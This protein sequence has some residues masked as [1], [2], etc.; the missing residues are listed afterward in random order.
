MLLR[1]LLDEPGRLF[2]KE[3]LMAALWPKAV[4]TDDSLVQCVGELRTALDDRAQRLIRTVPRRGYRL[5]AAVEKVFETPFSAPSAASLETAET[6][7]QVRRPNEMKTGQGSVWRSKRAWGWMAL[8]AAL[9]GGAALQL[10]SERA[11][12]HIDAMIAARS[13]VAIMRFVPSVDQPALRQLG[14]AVA[15]EIAAQFASRIGMRGIGRAATSDFDAAAPPLAR[16]GQTLKAT[17][18][19][20]GRISPGDADNSVSIDVQVTAV[21]T[22]QVIWAKHFERPQASTATL[23]SD[24]GQNVVN[25]IRN[26]GIRGDGIRTMVPS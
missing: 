4:V 26:K 1:L 25:A 7:A 6:P 19:V 12:V 10:R 17:H 13:T 15:D 23:P 3:D 2:S 8:A 9:M 11:P 14:D 24:V 5:E 20:T 22:C 18:V 21:A 16:I